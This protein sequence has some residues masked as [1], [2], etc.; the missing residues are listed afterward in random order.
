MQSAHIIRMLE[1]DGWQLVKEASADKLC[2]YQHPRKQGQVTVPH[3]VTL[4]L[5][6]AQSILKAAGLP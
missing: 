5:G 2:V 1:D 3:P 6:T 4:P